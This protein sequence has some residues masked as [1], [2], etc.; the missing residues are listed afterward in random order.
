MEALAFEV[1]N[2]KLASKDVQIRLSTH[3]L[4]FCHM[5]GISVPPLSFSRMFSEDPVCLP[6]TA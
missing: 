2:Y 6:T 1:S 4:S 5:A 3:C